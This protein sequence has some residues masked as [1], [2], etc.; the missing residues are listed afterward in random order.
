MMFCCVGLVFSRLMF[1]F[2]LIIIV[3]LDFVRC[4]LLYLFV[5]RFFVY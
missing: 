5:C 3:L 2:V 1:G 4:V